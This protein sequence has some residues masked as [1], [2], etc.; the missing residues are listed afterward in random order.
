M[1]NEQIFREIILSYLH[2]NY[3]WKG[4]N[5]NVGFDCS[6]LVVDILKSVGEFTY[7]G[8]ATP[9]YLFNRYRENHMS[10]KPQL[11][12]ICFYGK[13]EQRI[14]HC[15]IMLNDS[16]MLES[17]GGTSGTKSKKDA[18]EANARVRIRPYDYRKDLIKI[19]VPE[20]ELIEVFL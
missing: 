11:G 19:L 4:Q 12:A 18:I 1:N 5:P 16:M 2:Q 10:T 9:Q 20:Y 15:G 14:H 3:I 13:S 6:N 17:G 8:G 7:N